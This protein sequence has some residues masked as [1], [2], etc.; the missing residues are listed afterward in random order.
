ME[1]KIYPVN[2]KWIIE[3]AELYEKFK[4]E[5]KE[6]DKKSIAKALGVSE[7]TIQNAIGAFKQLELDKISDKIANSNLEGQKQLFRKAL[8]SYKPFLE[9]IFFLEKDDDP[10]K[11]IRKVLS[12]FEIKRKPKDAIRTFRN[13]GSFAGVFKGKNFELSK[14]IK[15]LKPSIMEDL[16]ESL[17]NEIKA[18]IWVKKILGA[19]ESYLSNEEY[20]SLIK[21]ILNVM[22][23]PREAVQSAG[24]ALEDFLRKLA[25][26]KGIDVSKKNGIYQIA[27]ELR[28]NNVL[29]SKHVP[30]LK[31]LQV[32][33]DRDIF[34][35]FAAFRNIAHHGKDKEEMK[36]WELSEELALSYII[37]VLLCIKSL[38]YYVM[39]EKLKF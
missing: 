32:F 38:Y 19:A 34:E 9:F 16:F 30:I 7:V 1:F 22:K 10:D 6:L 3:V 11:A 18:K 39:R 12:I 24:E 5:G 21:S 37:Q 36:K 2:A 14:S 28:K 35:G 4:K 25:H 27:E 31:G 33:L 26:D 15:S 29:A 20:E 13:W 23:D 8:Q 17:N